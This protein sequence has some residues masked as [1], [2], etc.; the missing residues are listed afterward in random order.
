MVDTTQPTADLAP[1]TA[2]KKIQDER[3]R[4]V[5][6][7]TRI[8]RRPELGALAGLVLVTIFFLSTA[9][10]SMFTLAGIMNILSPAAQLGIL[11][12]AAALLM[13]GGEFDLSIGSMVAFTGLVFGAFI[14][15]S[16]WPL[17]LAIAAT[18]VAAAVLGG[19]NGQM[20]IR[21]R[22]PSFIVT[23]AFL[24][25]LRGL[26]LVGLK[27]ATGGSTQMRGIGDQAGEGL[28]RELFSGVA[29][30]GVFSWLAAHDVIAKFPNGTPTVT[31]VPISIVWFVLFA[32]TATWLLLR[33]RAGNWIFAAGGD[34][35]AARN[36]GVPVDRV[37]TGLFML[38]A[39]AAALVAI[40][41]VLDAG[42]TDARRG[43][44]KEFEAIIA[45]VIGGCLLTG[46][47]G[48]AVGAFF[49]A[50]IFGMVSIG[51]TY[52]RFD[53][54]WFQVFLGAMLLLAVLFNNFIRRKVTGER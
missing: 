47:Y 32:L 19:L 52:T 1:A 31:G 17:L 5:S 2:V 36:S 39:C 35:N 21:T 49:G 9:D 53:S 13:I 29:F 44:Q 16:G 14:T 38:T 26:S 41:T 37:K 34:A 43:F 4:E 11:A 27:W 46:G 18:L 3:L 23:L 22:L 6:L 33:T 12:I 15:I 45:A 48:S 40:L 42:S 30:E 7:L 24:F 50:I 51:L 8:M 20:V 54:D 10:A 25:I 28:V